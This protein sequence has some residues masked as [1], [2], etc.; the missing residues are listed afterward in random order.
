MRQ[1]SSPRNSCSH[2]IGTGGEASLNIAQQVFLV[3]VLAIEGEYLLLC[4]YPK[5]K[6]SSM[7][8][9]PNLYPRKIDLS[10]ARTS[11]VI[12]VV[13]STQD[14]LWKRLWAPLSDCICREFQM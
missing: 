13:T 1:T 5:R 6:R 2:G 9:T 14:Q 11:A 3:D 12:L 7:T 10:A 4:V 8:H